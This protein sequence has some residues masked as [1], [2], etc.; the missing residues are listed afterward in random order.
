MVLKIIPKAISPCK[1]S[2]CLQAYVYDLR[3]S[4]YLYKLQKHTDTVLN[5][6]FNPATPEVRNPQ[7]ITTNLL[8]FLH[9]ACPHKVLAQV[10]LWVLC[11]LISY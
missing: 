2:H 3:S 9:R 4:S 10:S 1:L 7:Y 5:V 11:W 6:S 8:F